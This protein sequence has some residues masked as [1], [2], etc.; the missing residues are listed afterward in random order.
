MKL[1]LTCF[2]PFGG[3]STN[4][5]METAAALTGRL[6]GVTMVKKL[7]PVS[8]DMAHLR[9]Y[10]A[11]DEEKPDMVICTGQAAGSAELRVEKAAINC[12]N[13]SDLSLGG[14]ALED[15]RILEDA[16]DAYFSNLPV[17]EMAAAMKA[18]GVK[19]AVSYSAGTYVC[20][21]VMF[22][23]MERIRREKLPVLGGFIHIPLLSSQTEESAELPRIET[24]AAV[25]A[26]EAAVST[27][28][29]LHE[30]N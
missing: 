24:A 5:S 28:A 25:A 4:S 10:E 19:A 15:A 14:R 20:N 13:T 7:L 11:M 27:A 16:P 3:L 29:G 23:L 18:V 9:L 12:L 2:E 21:Y 1:L 17:R 30:E 6:P 26:L 8:F 22:R